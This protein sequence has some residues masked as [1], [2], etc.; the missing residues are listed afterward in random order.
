[1]DDLRLSLKFRSLLDRRGIKTLNSDETSF[2][3]REISFN[4]MLASQRCW[5]DLDNFQQATVFAWEGYPRSGL[6]DKT[7]S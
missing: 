5:S 7:A 1:M 4:L 2:S 6:V 3:A